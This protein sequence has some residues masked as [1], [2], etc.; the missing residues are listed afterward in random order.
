MIEQ[1]EEDVMGQPPSQ[2]RPKKA[3]KICRSKDKSPEGKGRWV[4]LS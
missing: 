1:G 2:S 4:N 3:G